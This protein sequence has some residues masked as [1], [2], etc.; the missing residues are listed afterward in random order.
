MRP[1][2]CAPCAPLQTCCPLRAHPWALQPWQRPLPPPFP[3]GWSCEVVKTR[4]RC[5][6][7]L[8]RK[9]E[10]GPKSRR[11]MSPGESWHRAVCLVQLGT[12]ELFLA[13]APFPDPAPFSVIVFYW[14]KV[15]CHS[16]V[17]WWCFMERARPRFPRKQQC[18][19]SCAVDSPRACSTE[20]PFLSHYWWYNQVKLEEIRS[21]DWNQCKSKFWWVLRSSCLVCLRSQENRSGSP[22]DPAAGAELPAR[23]QPPLGNRALR[24]GLGTDTE[25]CSFGLGDLRLCCG[26]SEPDC[27]DQF[28][29]SRRVQRLEGWK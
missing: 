9:G 26:S 11:L 22:P 20:K 28:W 8:Q 29:A 2:P 13:A 7:C 24:L 17:W 5:C 12:L 27:R 15:V 18:G 23:V 14:I 21:P 3:P 16:W 19:F 25:S 6:R 4:C 10:L 1:A